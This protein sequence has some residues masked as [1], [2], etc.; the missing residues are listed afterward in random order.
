MWRV[1][2]IGVFE[3]GWKKK[4]RILKKYETEADG[5]IERK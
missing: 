3:F 5:E 4:M 1:M 2:R